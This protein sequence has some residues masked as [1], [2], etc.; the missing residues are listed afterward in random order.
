MAVLVSDTSVV[1]DLERG[2]LLDLVFQLPH[3]F[4]VPDL[5][6]DRELAE[7]FGDRLIALG[8][9]VETL[10]GDEVAA[11][12][13]FTRKERSLSG[14]DAFAFSIAHARTWTLLTG[15]GALRRTAEAAGVAV[16]GVLWVLDQLEQEVVLDRLRLHEALSAIAAHPRCR[17]PR[18]EI[19]RRLAQYRP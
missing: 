11:A 12:A 19:A 7:E 4:A 16:H 10:S 17:L 14:P 5:L 2:G 6:F 9:R 8:L 1:Y 3:E 18:A 13:R 15:D